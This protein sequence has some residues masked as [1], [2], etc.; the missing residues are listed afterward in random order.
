MKNLMLAQFIMNSFDI[1]QIK[2]FE[3]F[4]ALL[5]I[6][7]LF[8]GCIII[9]LPHGKN[10]GLFLMGFGIFSVILFGASLV[11]IKIFNY[12]KLAYKNSLFFW[13]LG[14]SFTFI[15][16]IL[17]FK[18]KSAAHQTIY[19]V[20]NLNKNEVPLTYSALETFFISRYWL[21]IILSISFLLALFKF[22]KNS[23]K[24]K[25]N[26]LDS[27]KYLGAILIFSI[28]YG[29]YLIINPMYN[30]THPQ[31]VAFA[32]NYDF[33]KNKYCINI[34]KN[35]PIILSGDTAITVH[36]DPNKLFQYRVTYIKCKT[37]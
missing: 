4:I 12:L 37:K 28:A 30:Y 27:I 23:T 31:I 17:S 9:S 32:S 36:S 22:I 11:L 1:S 8:I 6:C 5:A 35:T 16:Y 10:I 2:K 26:P 34:P 15:T 24:E 13:T 20:F 25:E 19:S 14:V 29:L 7:G 33:I 21:I 3:N 18:A